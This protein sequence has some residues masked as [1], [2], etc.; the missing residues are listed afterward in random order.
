MYMN[1]AEWLAAEE[2]AE[3]YDPDALTNI[4][5]ARAQAALR[6]QDFQQFETLLLRAQQPLQLLQGY[7]VHPFTNSYGYHCTFNRFTMN[8][9]KKK[10]LEID[11]L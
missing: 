10:R 6:A 4:L 2:L 8:D 9:L 11:E 7:K 3:K 5:V 1:R